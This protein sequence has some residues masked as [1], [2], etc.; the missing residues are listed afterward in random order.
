MFEC[1][2]NSDDFIGYR[3]KLYPTESQKEILDKQFGCYRWIY[4]WGI[5]I[6]N[7]FHKLNNR[8]IKYLELCDEFEKVRNNPD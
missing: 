8:F 4:N 7:Q 2:A 6:V 1:K 3:I 5:D